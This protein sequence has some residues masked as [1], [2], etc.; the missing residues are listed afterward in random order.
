MKSDGGERVKSGSTAHAEKARV[1]TCK[2]CT[3]APLVLPRCLLHPH[4]PRPSRTI[5]SSIADPL[6]LSYSTVWPG[7]IRTSSSSSSAGLCCR[8]VSMHWYRKGCRSTE[9]ADRVLPDLAAQDGGL[10]GKPH[11]C[12]RAHSKNQKQNAGF[13]R[14]VRHATNH[15]PGCLRW[16]C[17]RATLPLASSAPSPPSVW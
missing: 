16:W 5:D 6:A 13:Q 12:P 15:H 2:P 7:K 3:H 10:D 11:Q 1:A 17:R 4:L 14:V 8:H 9:G